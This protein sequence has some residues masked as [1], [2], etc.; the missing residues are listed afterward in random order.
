MIKFYSTKD[1]YGWLSNYARHYFGDYPTNE[2]FYQSKKAITT[3][4]E[5]WIRNAPTPYAAMMAG[6]SLRPKEVR[7]DWD[8]VKINIML[9]G[10]R[11]KFSHPMFK[12]KL[13]ATCDEEIHEDSPTDMFWGILGKDMLGKLIM[14]VREELRIMEEVKRS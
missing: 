6:R 7:S 14:K 5:N 11:K 9:E 1:E 4:M 8:D 10:L 3:Q 12:N 13:L 2:H